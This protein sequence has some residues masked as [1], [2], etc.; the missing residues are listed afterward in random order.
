MFTLSSFSRCLTGWS[1]CTQLEPARSCSPGSCGSAS[2]PRF[3]WQRWRCCLARWRTLL[4]SCGSTGRRRSAGRLPRPAPAPPCRRGGCRVGLLSDVSL[5]ESRPPSL[6]QQVWDLL[7]SPMAA[8]AH[9][10][11]H[12]PPLPPHPPLTVGVVCFLP[13]ASRPM[14]NCQPCPRCQTRLLSQRLHSGECV[15]VGQTKKPLP[16]GRFPGWP[17]SQYLPLK[18]KTRQ[19]IQWGNRKEAD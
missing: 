8:C 9:P 10:P 5:C 11:P 18:A 16:A 17:H 2:S 1:S 6:G 19:E 15:C 7:R 14:T 13:F 4:S 3:L 12:W